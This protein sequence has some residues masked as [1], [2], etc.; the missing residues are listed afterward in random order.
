ML[1]S[2]ILQA[3][4]RDALLGDLC[5]EYVAR[6][7]AS[8]PAVAGWY[9]S[10]VLRSLPILLAS[11]ARRNRWISTVAIALAA[12][13]VVGALNMAGNSI[14]ERWLGGSAGSTNN[15]R[16]AIVGLIAIGTGAH[17]A[18]RLRRPAG[19][20]LGGLVMLVAVLLLLFPVD[21]SPL[22]Y[23]LTFLILGPLAAH[24]GAIAMRDT[25]PRD[26]RPS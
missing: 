7:S 22:W 25:T 8:R 19:D 3:G 10:Q 23:Q 6:V 4:E 9:W 24:L 14:V 11:R 17:L 20:V 26:R 12:Y 2:A 13:I 21:A 5:E 16:S 1:L 18:S 15:V